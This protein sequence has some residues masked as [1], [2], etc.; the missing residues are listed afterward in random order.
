MKTIDALTLHQCL[1]KG[2]NYIIID[3][4]EPY[5]REICN[6]D[7]ISIPMGDIHEKY[8][9]IPQSSKAVI[10]CRSGQRAEAVINYLESNF[11]L[12]N[13]WLLEGGLM[14]WIDKVDQQLEKY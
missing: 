12:N 5:E 10:M 4:R 7:A 3:V 13:L 1:Q 14:A 2:E 11:H 8:Q 9:E 6:I